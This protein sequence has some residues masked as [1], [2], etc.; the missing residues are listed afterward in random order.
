MDMSGQGRAFGFRTA[1]EARTLVHKLMV[2]APLVLA[3]CIG[4]QSRTSVDEYEPA[5]YSS[6]YEARLEAYIPWVREGAQLRDT[7][8]LARLRT[9]A[10][11]WVNARRDG[12][13]ASL[14]PVDYGDPSNIGVK[15][16]I[17]SLRAELG[18]H[19]VRSAEQAQASGEHRAAISDALLAFE[20]AE[21][22]KYF[23]LTSVFNTGLEQ[24]TALTVV[25][26]SLAF[27]GAEEQKRTKAQLRTLLDGQGRLDGLAS[28]S[29]RHFQAY[30]KLEK[31]EPLGIEDSQRVMALREIVAPDHDIREGV[32]DLRDLMV[33]S[34]DPE[35]PVLISEVRGALVSQAFV[36]KK[37]RGLLGEKVDLDFSKMQ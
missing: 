37:L 8:D 12:K 17:T 24:R 3:L 20:F 9:F 29:R 1:Q 28:L 21:A 27:V 32:R 11:R 4:V 31:K 33:A 34:T 35:V 10:R 5:G 23:D 7:T 26:R 22:T 2:L 18:L 14:E 16:Q 15:G 36:A 19:L 13:L 30:R 25:G 6:E